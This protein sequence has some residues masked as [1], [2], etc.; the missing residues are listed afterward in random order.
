MEELFS[1]S[2]CLA[3]LKESEMGAYALCWVS[4]IAPIYL[5]ELRY[6]GEVNT[7]GIHVEAV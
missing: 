2:C 3:S 1:A 7:E 5:A 6:L 4:L